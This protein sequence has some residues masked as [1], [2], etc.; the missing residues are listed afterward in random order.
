MNA[1]G[2]IH[3]AHEADP[4]DPRFQP[5]DLHLD[6]ARGLRIRW[7]DGRESF[8]PLAYLRRLCPCA[9]CRTEREEA[10]P[11]AAGRSLTI[12]P[13]GIE[14][15]TQVVD[16]SVMGRYAINIVWGDGHSTG[17]YDFR[18]LRSIAPPDAR[19]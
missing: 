2:T 17:I 3:A 13:A 9:T 8:Y 6:R 19:E 10:R 5:A 11:S 1:D 15:A 7:A 4:A 16:A 18:Y 14:R 12:L